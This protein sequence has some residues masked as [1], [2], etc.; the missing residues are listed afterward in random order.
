MLPGCVRPPLSIDVCITSDAQRRP[1]I[2][3]CLTTP[4]QVQRVFPVAV[5]AA[6]C[7]AAMAATVRLSARLLCHSSCR[8]Y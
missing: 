3:R 1:A 6:L 4:E 7:A 2:W 5:L 8:C